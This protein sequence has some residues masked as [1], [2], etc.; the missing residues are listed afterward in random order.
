MVYEQV[1]FNEGVRYQIKGH[2]YMYLPSKKSKSGFEYGRTR[3]FVR[4]LPSALSST[5]KE[6]HAEYEPV[7]VEMWLTYAHELHHHFYFL[8]ETSINMNALHKQKLFFF[9][10]VRSCTLALRVDWNCKQGSLDINSLA[11]FI[12][13]AYKVEEVRVEIHCPS[14]TPLYEGWLADVTDLRHKTIPKLMSGFAGR[15]HYGNLMMSWGLPLGERLRKLDI[16]M[17][18]TLAGSPYVYH[19]AHA[20]KVVD[21]D[22]GDETW[23]RTKA[24]GQGGYGMNAQ[25][26]RITDM[27]KSPSE[28]EKWYSRSHGG[29]TKRRPK[30]ARFDWDWY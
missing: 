3:T 5:C 24:D 2:C 4:S 23:A 30:D 16:Y 26:K 19:T 20:E 7:E 13:Q 11:M 22:T 9:H 12:A 28:G 25:G 8:D 27:I 15:D 6:I 18:S 29:R 21:K 1:V 14:D 17:Y 10:D